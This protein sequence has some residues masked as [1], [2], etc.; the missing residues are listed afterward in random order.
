MGQSQLCVC[1]IITKARPCDAAFQN[2]G[3]REAPAIHA[4]ADCF[5][6]LM[7]MGLMYVGCSN[8]SVTI[9]V[10]P[11]AADMCL[12]CMSMQTDC[13]GAGHFQIWPPHGERIAHR[14]NGLMH[15]NKRP[16]A[17]GNMHAPHVVHTHALQFI[18]VHSNCTLHWA[19]TQAA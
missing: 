19:H 10:R 14:L 6:H 4:H 16:L 7:M 2:D 8:S 18:C 17:R 9:R 15:G 5:V 3:V 13:N 1:V 12:S 11:S